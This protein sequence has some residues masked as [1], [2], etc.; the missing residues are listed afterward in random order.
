MYEATFRRADGEELDHM[1]APDEAWRGITTAAPDASRSFLAPAQVSLI[2]RPQGKYLILWRSADDEVGMKPFQSVLTGI[3]L[4]FVVVETLY[5]RFFSRPNN[6]HG[7][8]TS[9][10]S[11]TSKLF[12]VWLQLRN[13]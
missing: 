5:E 9:L 12:S 13:S 1:F 10:L 2:V 8:A 6:S 7:W 3:W 11:E 4:F